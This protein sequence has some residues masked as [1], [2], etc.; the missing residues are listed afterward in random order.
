MYYRFNSE[1]MPKV[2]TMGYVDT[3]PTWR[4]FERTCNEFILYI[5]ADGVMYIRQDDDCYELHRGDAI[6]FDPEHPQSGYEESK[7]SYYYIHVRPDTFTRF[8]CSEKQSI[9]HLLLDNRRNFIH[10]NPISYEQYETTNLYIPKVINI[11]DSKTMRIIEKSMSES[12]EALELGNEYYKLI[13]TTKFLEII[14]AMSNYFTDKLFSVDTEINSLRQGNHIT[15]AVMEYLRANYSKKI[16]GDMIAEC[17]EMNFDYL[18]RVFKKY[19]GCTIF[20]YLKIIRINKAKELLMNRNMKIYEIADATGFS[21][22]FHF[23]RVF[24]AETGMS[25]KKYAI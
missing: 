9:E 11:R 24:K 18:N 2:S 4:H 5:V 7:C 1:Y 15:E 10:T 20:E 13:C 21:D 19:L 3:S 17:L 14:T 6:L 12:I 25:P 22:E 23:S 8:D 16:T